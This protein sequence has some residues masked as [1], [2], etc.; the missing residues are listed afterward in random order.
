MI[1]VKVVCC[2]SVRTCRDYYTGV[3]DIYKK[4]LEI[5]RATRCCRGEEKILRIV[6]PERYIV[7]HDQ[8]SNRGKHN[9]QIVHKPSSLSEREVMRIVC[10]VLGL[11]EVEVI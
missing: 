5:Y 6:E 2:Y 9:I 7:F 4:T 11:I 3:I 8:V 10:E 1:E